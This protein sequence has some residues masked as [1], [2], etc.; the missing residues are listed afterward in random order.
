MAWS[1]RAGWHIRVWKCLLLG[2]A[3]LAGYA[4]SNARWVIIDSLSAAS[5]LLPDG[6]ISSR[7]QGIYKRPSIKRLKVFR[8]LPHT[9]ELHW[10][11]QLV[12]Y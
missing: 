4:M 8:R 11:L 7:K 3:V 10:E 5:Q 12:H 1:V 9:Y 6:A 2:S